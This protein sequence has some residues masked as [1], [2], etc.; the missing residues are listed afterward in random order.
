MQ[1]LRAV[2]LSIYL[3]I[4]YNDIEVFKTLLPSFP[5]KEPLPNGMTLMQEVIRHKRTE[6]LYLLLQAGEPI[7]FE[8][9]NFLYPLMQPSHE[10]N[11][12]PLRS[13]SM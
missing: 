8:V 5:L 10:D 6:M 7:T 12:L 4:R 2:Q 1:A 13:I 3:T 11:S 9:F